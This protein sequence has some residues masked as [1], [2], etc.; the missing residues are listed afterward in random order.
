[1]A[2]DVGRAKAIALTNAMDHEIAVVHCVAFGE[3]GQVLVC[4]E[5]IGLATGKWVRNGGKSL[6]RRSGCRLRS[7]GLGR[8]RR[9]LFRSEGADNREV[10]RLHHHCGIWE[11]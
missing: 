9:V 2:E 8:C 10:G 5:G 6:C 7:G 4:R 1:M 11:S 3:G